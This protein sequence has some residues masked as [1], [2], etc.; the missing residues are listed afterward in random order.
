MHDRI[1]IDPKRC[2]GK[3]V[4]KGTR[5]PVIVV[6]DELANG[7]SFEASLGGYP[8]LAVEDL[9]AAVQYA[10]ASVEQTEFIATNSAGAS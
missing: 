1:E 4:I 9:Q 10:K 5:I 2:G 7:E 3:P 6:L 8:E